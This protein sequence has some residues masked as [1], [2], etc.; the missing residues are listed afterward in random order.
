[1]NGPRLSLELDGPRLSLWLGWPMFFL[2]I[3]RW[4]LVKERWIRLLLLRRMV[5]CVF[6]GIIVAWFE[7]A[8]ASEFPEV[9]IT[10][11]WSEVIFAVGSS[12]VPIAVG[13]SE[14]ANIDGWSDVIIVEPEVVTAVG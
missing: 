11:G 9:A 1:M 7:V 12:E 5:E 6:Q 13:W 3:L 14:I 8:F 2:R 10:G 4:L